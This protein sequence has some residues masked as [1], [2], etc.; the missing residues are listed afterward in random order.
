MRLFLTTDWMKAN[1]GIMKLL[2]LI[3]PN[4]K[5]LKFDEEFYRFRAND[6]NSVFGEKIYVG[7]DLDLTYNL[8]KKTCTRDFFKSNNDD[9]WLTGTN[10]AD[11]L[12]GKS[13][14]EMMGGAETTEEQGYQFGESL[15]KAYN[16]QKEIKKG[17]P[18]GVPNSVIV[19]DPIIEMACDPIPF[20]KG[21]NR[22]IIDNSTNAPTIYMF[23]GE[24]PDDPSLL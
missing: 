19:F 23:G 21:L 20:M 18:K 3:D 4:L 16:V 17:I 6:A 22:A 10:L 8:F 2:N 5:G 13:A 14:I 11:L 7:D 9:F 24:M 12:E 1:E 15:I